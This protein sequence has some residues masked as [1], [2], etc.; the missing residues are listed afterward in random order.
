MSAVT[1]A[2]IF[3]F[4][5]LAV[6]CWSFFDAANRY[7]KIAPV[8]LLLS[9]FI[10][11]LIGRWPILK[12]DLV[13]NPDEALMAANAMLAHHGWLNW[14]FADTLT[15]GPLDS[16]VLTWPKLFGGDI[17][18]FSARLT[19]IILLGIALSSLYATVAL[20]GNNRLA[21]ISITPIYAFLIFTSWFDFIH[22]TS[23]LLPIALISAGLFCYSASV[24]R[25][26]TW[27]LFLGAFLLGSV[28]MAKLQGTP[29]AMIVGSF[30]VFRVFLTTSTMSGRVTRVATILA[31]ASAP[32]LLFLVPLTLAGGFNDF[33]KSYFLQQSLRVTGHAWHDQVPRMIEQCFLFVF[34]CYSTIILLGMAAGTANRYFQHQ[35]FDLADRRMFVLA[36]LLLPVSYLSIAASGRTYTHYLLLSIPAIVM[37]S[38]ASCAA[39]G[40]LFQNH[41][42]ASIRTALP[43]GAFC[44]VTVFGSI[45]ILEDNQP[46]WENS[47]LLQ[48]FPFSEPRS[49]QW[50]S[51]LPTD[52]LLCWGWSAEC[53]LNSAILPATREATNE[54]QIYKTRLRSYFRRRFIADFE[55]TK[56][57]FIVD[58][59]V[60]TN[61][62]GFRKPQTQGAM[63][64]PQLAQIISLDYQLVSAA[65][66]S[67]R[68]PR[69]YVLKSRAPAIEA[70]LVHFRSI[71][72]TASMP[73]FSPPAL[74]DGSVFETCQDYWLAPENTG[75]S[76]DIQFD[77]P[78][79]VKQ[80]AI[81]NT[82]DGK[83]GDRSAKDIR[84]RLMLGDQ[85]VRTLEVRLN[86]FPRWTMI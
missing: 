31:A 19:G 28:P 75:G 44:I 59:V 49:L 41:Q 5:S 4:V 42:S 32:A 74:D 13:L 81:L 24:R 69:L 64:F 15:A 38:G 12:Y 16:M 40:A 72:A 63:A 29:I 33:V 73:G 58:T 45:F 77:A 80:I 78:S 84:I 47:L 52:H 48:G 6:F 14:N 66:P 39:V 56:P 22:Y 76:I 43:I 61:I 46:V 20:L 37:A 60:P 3:L 18:L 55:N 68:C 79:A 1:M 35:K 82:R 10:S 71:T 65:D 9:A 23:E 30:I 54:N 83:T 27:P 11:L 85:L 2:V 25:H 26:L 57:A 70:R 8:I 62:L 36:L 67:D 53:Y 17:T 51:P 21:T 7:P 34:F 50:L 86:K